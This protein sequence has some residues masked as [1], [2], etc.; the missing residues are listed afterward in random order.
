[1]S[2]GSVM[3]SIQN[4]GHLSRDRW[5]AGAMLAAVI[6]L[7]WGWIAPM[8]LDMYGP[9]TGCSAWMMT[10]TWDFPHQALLFAMWAVMMVG[11]MLPS[12]VPAV[13]RYASA[14]PRPAAH[15]TGLARVSAFVAGYLIVWTVFSLIA[16]AL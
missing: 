13:F 2:G 12:A 14:A 10:R 1:M 15:D 16:T 4:E 5:L 11:M 3:T 7:C 9:M 8:A 6:A